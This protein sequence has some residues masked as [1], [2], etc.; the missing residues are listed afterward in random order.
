MLAAEPNKMAAKMA[1]LQ[2]TLS[3]VVEALV[4]SAC[5]F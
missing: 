4:P 3:F 2:I 5:L 1:A